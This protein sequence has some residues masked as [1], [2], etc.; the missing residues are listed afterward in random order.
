MQGG[1]DQDLRTQHLGTGHLELK[2]T[3]CWGGENRGVQGLFWGLLSLG[4]W[5]SLADSVVL[6]WEGW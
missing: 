4:P 5:W 2:E 6:G 3:T 1:W